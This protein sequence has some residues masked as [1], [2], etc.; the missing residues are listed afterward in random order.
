M[1]GK[2][3]QI[4][5]NP[6]PPLGRIK[7]FYCFLYLYLFIFLWFTFCGK[8][9]FH[10][11]TRLCDPSVFFPGQANQ[12]PAFAYTQSKFK[13]RRIK[14]TL[15]KHRLVFAQVEYM[16]KH[17]SVNSVPSLFILSPRSQVP[18]LFPLLS[19]L[20]SHSSLKLD[21]TDVK[22]AFHSHCFLVL[23]LF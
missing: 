2:Y 14:Q 18:L 8:F 19:P 23:L 1:K 17:T 22:A 16:R 4:L 20:L 10:C 13:Q 5:A 21:F 15:H 3:K 6:P 9:K 7:V 12:L 11:L